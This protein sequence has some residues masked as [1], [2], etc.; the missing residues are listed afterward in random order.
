MG[1]FDFLKDKGKKTEAGVD[2]ST[3]ERAVQAAMGGRLE[4]FSV[5]FANGTAT[6][7]GEA[8]SRADREQAVLLAGNI[9]GVE[10]VNDDRLRV[11]AAEATPE[12]RAETATEDA[13]PTFYT[14]QKGDSLSAIAKA[15]YGDAGKWRALYDANRAVIGDDPDRIYPGQQIRVPEL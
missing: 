11:K 7:S 3:I 12:A 15:Q 14:V 2:A 1:L 5:A 8:A 10:R 4:H 13:A 6:L 9:Q